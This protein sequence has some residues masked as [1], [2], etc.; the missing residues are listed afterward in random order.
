MN[1]EY[2]LYSS[3][4]RVAAGAYDDGVTVTPKPAEAAKLV[5]LLQKKSGGGGDS[6]KSDD[7]GDK[8]KGSA[9]RK[10]IDRFK[11]ALSK[12]NLRGKN[13]KSG[14][15]AIKDADPN[16]NE[17]ATDTGRHEWSDKNGRVRARYDPKGANEDAHWDKYA[18]DGTRID[19][20]GRPGTE[21]IP[22]K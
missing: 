20:A 11:D 15:N 14:R 3:A 21:H 17:T 13:L 8:N 10:A 9:I 1:P 12:L 16:L 19:N 4:R 2:R 7:K 18:P 5:A 22:A 6:D